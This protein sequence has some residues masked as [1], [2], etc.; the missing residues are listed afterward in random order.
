VLV[1]RV[2]IFADPPVPFSTRCVRDSSTL[3]SSGS[4]Q[5][6][7]CGI[8]LSYGR[9]LGRSLVGRLE[10]K[11]VCTRLGNC[12][13][14]YMFSYFFPSGYLSIAIN[15]ASARGAHC[16]PE[17]LGWL[18]SCGTMNNTIPARTHANL[19]IPGWAANISERGPV[20][21][22]HAYCCNIAIALT[23]VNESNRLITSVGNFRSGTST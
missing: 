11:A 10:G 2:P 18:R 5:P 20:T 9:N 1:F 13:K 16:S 4:P 6:V 22:N 15:L 14:P 12:G 7:E 23:T 8:L 19:R 3:F 17:P 21:V